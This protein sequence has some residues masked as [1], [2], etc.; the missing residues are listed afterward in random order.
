MK[1]IKKSEF[2]K[3]DMR[4]RYTAV[5]SRTGDISV[6]A[7][8]TLFGII[9]TTISGVMLILLM[10]DFGG[11][12]DDELMMPKIMISVFVLIGVLILAVAVPNTIRSAGS[13]AS[14]KNAAKKG[15][16]T[17]GRI[18]N[19]IRQ[20]RSLIISY[21]F[22]DKRSVRCSASVKT[23]AGSVTYVNTRPDNQNRHPGYVAG[24][25]IAILFYGKR[26]FILKEYEL[27]HQRVW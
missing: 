10:N 7:F 22:T 2:R 11:T 20:S 27:T 5:D 6:Y 15:L 9:W 23:P 21:S 18:D 1:D 25:E 14:L 26:S 3:L 4:S 24:M 13:R 19:V 16:V 17:L 8:M 12:D